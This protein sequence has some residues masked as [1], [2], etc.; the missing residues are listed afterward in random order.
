M[1]HVGRTVAE[2]PLQVPYAKP[3]LL[4]LFLPSCRW[5]LG[6]GVIIIYHLELLYIV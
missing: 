5:Q 6:L 2:T 3:L 4:F 1:P